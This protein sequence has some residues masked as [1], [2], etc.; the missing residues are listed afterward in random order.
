MTKLTFGRL[1]PLT[2]LLSSEAVA[3]G[4]PDKICDQVSDALL[5]AALRQDRRARVAIETA[6]KDNEVWVFGE[7][8]GAV[9]LD[10][11]GTV[12]ETLKSIGH[13]DGRWGVD[14]DKLQIRTALSQQAQEIAAGLESD[15]RLGAGD[16]GIMF[17]YATAETPER[18]PLS[19]ALAR[20]LIAAHTQ[21][22]QIH[23]VLGPDA[24]AQVSVEIASDGRASVRTIVLSSQHASELALI[25]LRE[26]LLQT[27]IKAV[28]P[29]LE[30]DVRLLIN[31]A[32]A[33]T[34][35]G[36]VADAGVTGRKIIVDTYGGIGRHGGGAFS[37]KDATKVDRS[38]AYGAR[39]LACTVVEGGLSGTAEV[40]LAY[41]IGVAEPVAIHID[42]EHPEAAVRSGWHADR[43]ADL[44]TPRSLIDRLNLD[45]PV[46]EACAREGHFGAGRPWDRSLKVQQMVAA[47]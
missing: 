26:L 47:A 22:R 44:F 18:L 46:Y 28:F 37:G 9:D 6:I 23:G 5:D 39:Q 34:Q 30:S 10:V 4:H 32:G 29:N 2:G 8:S 3:P 40:R 36:P 21:A 24:K 45:A 42:V 25:D 41:A 43:V 11:V 14:V 27:V 13:T 19:F 38:A 16:Q 12:Q 7:L 17:G 33:F 31:P 20:R 15:E 1:Q 35:G